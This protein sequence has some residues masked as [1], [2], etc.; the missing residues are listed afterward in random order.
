MLNVRFLAR[1]YAV[2]DDG[3]IDTVVAA[4]DYTEI[5]KRRAREWAATP[6]AP[7]TPTFPEISSHVAAHDARLT[8]IEV[9]IF[10]G[11]ISTTTLPAATSLQHVDAIIP[12]PRDVITADNFTSVHD[13]LLDYLRKSGHANISEHSSVNTSNITNYLRNNILTLWKDDPVKRTF[14]KGNAPKL[15]LNRAGWDELLKVANVWVTGSVVRL[16]K[17]PP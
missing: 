8:A 7:K 14:Y 3:M 10:G 16:M 1:V 9:H 11:P 4:G 5:E 17:L 12:P 2:G 6:P 13:N 15:Q